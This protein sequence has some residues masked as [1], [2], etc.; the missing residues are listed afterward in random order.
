MANCGDVS[1]AEVRR[2]AALELHLPVEASSADIT[3]KLTT[4]LIECGN[5][6]TL[7]L[8]DAVTHKKVIRG[9]AL[10]RVAPIARPRLLALSVVELLSASWA[11]LELL[12]PE[13]EA[14]AA[15]PTV[16][17]RAIEV[18]QRKRTPR[19]TTVATVF[20]TARTFGAQ[21][22][23][24]GGGVQVAVDLGTRAAL[25]PGV[26]A[27]VTLEHAAYQ[28]SLGTISIDIASAG[29]SAYLAWRLGP[30]TIHPGVGFQG[31]RVAQA[32]KP[33]DPVQTDGRSGSGWYASPLVS[34]GASVSLSKSWLIQCTPEAG[35]VV[36]PVG[37]YVAHERTV[38]V[39]GPWFGASLGVGLAL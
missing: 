3:S 1:P 19:A 25:V 34:L 20:G 37:I 28:A 5:E 35:Y 13:V 7:T 6:T 24:L 36:L 11:E 16:R 30:L 23:A 26:Q 9:L 21:W 32:G 18:V 15:S 8:V 33:F 38:A 2:I 12:P 14:P 39:E 31:G 27:N 29:L 17:A 10:D 22:G 4:V